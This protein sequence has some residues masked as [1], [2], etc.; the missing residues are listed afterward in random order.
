MHCTTLFPPFYMVVDVNIKEIRGPTAP[1]LAM[2]PQK[3][4]KEKNTRKNYN[5]LLRLTQGAS[6]FVFLNTYRPRV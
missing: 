1:E 2:G 4:R 3:W 5:P 6:Q